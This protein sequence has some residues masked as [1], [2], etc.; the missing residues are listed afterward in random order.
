[1][2]FFCLGNLATNPADSMSVLFST[3]KYR[4]FVVILSFMLNKTD[5]KFSTSVLVEAKEVVRSLQEQT[6]ETFRNILKDIDCQEHRVDLN[7][8]RLPKEKQPARTED[9][10]ESEASC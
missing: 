3:P 9:G 7:F 6:A 8:N 1:M 2:V 4:A 5:K 10:Q